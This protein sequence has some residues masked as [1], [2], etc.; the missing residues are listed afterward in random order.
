M[1]EEIMDANPKLP[2]VG[3]ESLRVAVYLGQDRASLFLTAKGLKPATILELVF[4]PG[5]QEYTENDYSADINNCEQMLRDLGLPYEPEHYNDD[6]DLERHIFLV[7]KDQQSLKDLA[8]AERADNSD[9]YSYGMALGKALGYPETA[10]I[11]DA[12]KSA[13]PISEYPPELL[14]DPS[15]KFCVFALSREHWQEEMEVVKQQAE[16]IKK[17]D[18]SLY[19]AIL[20]N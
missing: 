4:E 16:F 18:P 15:R 10:I 20:N 3:Y 14:N 5:H 7:G 9:Y 8:T 11:A 19:N 2:E 1:D 12:T 6:E 13:M 17:E